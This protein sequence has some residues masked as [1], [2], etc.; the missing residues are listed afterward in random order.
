MFSTPTNTPPRPPAK[1][2]ADSSTTGHFCKMSSPCINKQPTNDVIKVR[3]PDRNVIQSTHTAL[4]DLP[5]LPLATR[6]AYIFPELASHSL[7]SITQLCDNGCTS[8]F[9]NK[10]VCTKH[11]NVVL[12]RG[13]CH[14]VTSLYMLPL[15]QA[16]TTLQST[17]ALSSCPLLC[18]PMATQCETSS[19][20]NNAYEMHKKPA[21]LRNLHR[22]CFSPA[23]TTWTMT[24]QVGKFTTWPGLTV[25]AIYKHLTKSVATAKG[26]MKQQF[27]NLRSTKRPQPPNMI[28][29]DTPTLPVS[30]KTPIS[31]ILSY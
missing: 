9:D 17:V 31:H 19:C 20:A 6:T 27:K 22:C 2:I 13:A 28:P 24:V 12:L 7:L 11:E 1:S 5:T 25:D 23:T 8:T 30:P 4:L 26:H 16:S 18:A 10:H 15:T 3:L 29:L 14:P 21:L